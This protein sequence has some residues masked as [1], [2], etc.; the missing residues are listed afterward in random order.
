MLKFMKKWARGKISLLYEV[1][2]MFNTSC[3]VV[4]PFTSKFHEKGAT[5]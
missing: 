3:S 5:F 1:F 4:A 2:A